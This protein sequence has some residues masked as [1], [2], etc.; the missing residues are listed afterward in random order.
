M[1][2]MFAAW[3]NR[4]I[5]NTRQRH[6]QRGS[7]LPDPTDKLKL[8]FAGYNGTR[9]TG[10]DVRVE[11]MLRQVRHLYGE[12]R[13]E[14]TVFSFIKS[15]SAAYFGNAQQVTPAVTFPRYL[16]QI[17]PRFHGVVA[18]E[19]STFKSNFSDL[20][21]LM[22][23][24]ALGVA[25]ASDKL[26]IAYGAEAGQMNPWPK[27]LTRENCQQ[28]LVLTRNAASRDILGELGVPSE[29]GTDT[30]WTFSPLPPAYGQQQLRNAGWRGEP[31][32]IVCPINPFCWPVTASLTK[33]MARLLGFYRRSHYGRIFFFNSDPSVEE[34]FER[35]LTAVARGVAA[36][37][38][39]TGVFVAL[40]ASEEIDNVA[41]RRIAAKLGGAP[42]FSSTNY[43]IYQLVSIFRAADLMLSSRYHAIVTSMAGTVASAG[44]TVDE[45]I[46]NLMNER[47]HS[48][49]LAAVDDPD[50]EARVGDMLDDLQANAP[51]VIAASHRV[52]AKNLQIM[53][54]MGTRFVD[55][56]G[57]RFPNFEPRVRSRSWENYLPPLGRELQSLL[58]DQSAVL[59]PAASADQ[60]MGQVCSP[61]ANMNSEFAEGCPSPLAVL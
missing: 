54:G 10:S 30:A 35:Y 31:V 11:E 2:E 49:L 40:A 37:R 1:D 27:R 26:S 7:S 50:L 47:G 5:A 23:V 19:G 12:H 28:S 20:L 4:V 45:R 58:A 18:C 52:V 21:T 41:V 22:M 33:G 57:Q 44:I 15:Y 36:F 17:V 3:M 29:L 56:V 48:R 9:N 59:G 53:A 51:A 61:V 14:A 13:V 16:G 32:L 39:R 6:L 42:T 25:A 43:N 24:G 46:A 55:Y 38:Q 34:R 8:L 60:T